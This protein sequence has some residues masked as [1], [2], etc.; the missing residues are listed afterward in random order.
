MVGDHVGQHVGVALKNPVI[1]GSIELIQAGSIK[2]GWL[3]TPTDLQLLSAGR[4]DG[5][6]I[7]FFHRRSVFFG[8]GVVEVLASYGCLA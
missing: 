3:E 6:C 8:E 5:L 7:L 2:N 1:H 4:R